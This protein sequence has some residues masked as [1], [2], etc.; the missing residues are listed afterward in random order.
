MLVPGFKLFPSRKQWGNARFRANGT[1]QFF[2]TGNNAHWYK[3]EASLADVL[4]RWPA[5]SASSQVPAP[6]KEGGAITLGITEA[7]KAL[8]GSVDR[9]PKALG[10]KERNNKILGW[11]KQKEYSVPKGEGL[12]R[13]VQRVIKP[14]A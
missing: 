5:S 7:I 11:L 12:A 9:I 8:W 10:A 6:H 2:Q 4:R 13:A 14:R 3:F 1:V